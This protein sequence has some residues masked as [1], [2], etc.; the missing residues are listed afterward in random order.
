MKRLLIGNVISSIPPISFPLLPPLY[1]PSNSSIRSGSGSASGT[2]RPHGSRVVRFYGGHDDSGPQDLIVTYFVVDNLLLELSDEERHDVWYS[3]QELHHFRREYETELGEQMHQ[4]DMIEGRHLPM[5]TCVSGP[6][7]RS[8]VAFKVSKGWGSR[9]A[10][11]VGVELH[12]ESGQQPPA[13][14]NFS[15]DQ[16]SSSCFSMM[17]PRT[18]N[19]SFFGG[20]KMKKKTKKSKSSAGR[21]RERR[22]MLR[23]ASVAPSDQQ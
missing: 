21:Q 6:T 8:P 23:C 11:L 15:S 4:Q 18:S 2:R 10:A 17:L 13:K 16:P 9:A 14:G 3:R 1:S 19:Y 22:P 12:E 5:A 7:G 20:S